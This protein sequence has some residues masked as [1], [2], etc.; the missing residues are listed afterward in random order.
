MATDPYH[1]IKALH[2]PLVH[3]VLAHDDWSPWARKR[4][5]EAAEHLLEVMLA[6]AGPECRHCGVNVNLEATGRPRSY[7]SDACRQAA[8]RSRLTQRL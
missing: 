8:Y 4:L 1:Q 3:E 5:Q 7:C 2:D 6:L